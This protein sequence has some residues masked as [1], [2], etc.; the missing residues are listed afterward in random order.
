MF[1]E[2]HPDVD[3]SLYY[4]QTPQQIPALRQRRVLIVFERLLPNE[5]DIQV[6]L[7]ARERLLLAVSNRHAL[8]R[9]KVVP[10]SA[11]KDQTLRVGTAPAGM[12]TAEELCRSSGFEPRF[13]GEASD[14][15][16]ATLLTA[17]GD[18]ITLVPAS[19]ANVRI[20]GVTY[21]DLDP[22]V[23]SF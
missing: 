22:S 1:R 16:M 10:V 13:A 19:M 12:T 15:V 3:V 7:V 23:N 14:V 11:L 9:R 5:S 2:T 20:P 17:I 4:A 18:E 21:L 8:A 6:T